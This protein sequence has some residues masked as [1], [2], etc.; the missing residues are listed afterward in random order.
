[1]RYEKKELLKRDPKSP[2]PKRELIFKVLDARSEQLKVTHE[3]GR[4]D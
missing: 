2:I 3:M 1:M 4:T